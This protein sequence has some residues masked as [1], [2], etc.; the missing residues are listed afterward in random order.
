MEGKAVNG[1]DKGS[2][3]LHTIAILY[4]KDHVKKFL[5]CFSTIPWEGGGA[6]TTATNK[7]QQ[8]FMHVRPQ[9]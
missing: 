4:V 8:S 3:M 2:E 6:T 1:F 7:R 9:C 5:L